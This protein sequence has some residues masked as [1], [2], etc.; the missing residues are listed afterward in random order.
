M[1]IDWH[2][3]VGN[4]LALPGMTIGRLAKV[5]GTKF[6]VLEW[7]ILERIK[8]PPFM[9]GLHLLNLHSDKFGERETAGLYVDKNTIRRLRAA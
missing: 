7:I 3:C 2:R 6:W 5:V 4:L 9:A 8:E 1:K